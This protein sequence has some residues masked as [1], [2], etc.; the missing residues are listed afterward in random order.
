MLHWI[1]HRDQRILLSSDSKEVISD[2]EYDV[3]TQ[4]LRR[5]LE[6]GIVSKADYE[7]ST[8]VKFE[9]LQPILRD[10]AND[11]VCHDDYVSPRLYEDEVSKQAKAFVESA[12]NNIT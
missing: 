12:I 1:R 7:T 11:L 6:T 4:N 3:I 9:D 5:S 2:N 8:H 10:I